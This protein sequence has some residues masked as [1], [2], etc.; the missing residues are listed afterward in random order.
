MHNYDH[1]DI[2]AHIV[3]KR[4]H[5]DLYDIKCENLVK[6]FPAEC[7]LRSLKL[8][9][10][11]CT[12]FMAASSQLHTRDDTTLISVKYRCHNTDMSWS[13]KNNQAGH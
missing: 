12:S 9:C 5:Y 10:D 6:I 8:S 7:V 11:E 1:L 2:I 3:I 4:L 13:R